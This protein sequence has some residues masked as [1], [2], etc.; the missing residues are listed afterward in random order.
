MSAPLFVEG[1][2]PPGWPSVPRTIDEV[3]SKSVDRFSGEPD[4]MEMRWRLD[5]VLTVVRA[6]AS[7]LSPEA[8]A[9]VAESLGYEPAKKGVES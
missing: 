8:Q 1:A 3:I 5:E 9:A 2:I 7:A 6:I 4:S